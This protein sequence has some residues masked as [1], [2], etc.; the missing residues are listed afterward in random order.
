[1]AGAREGCKKDRVNREHD[2]GYRR[3]LSVKRVFLDFLRDFVTRDLMAHIDQ[4]TLQ[5]VQQSFVLPDFSGKEADLVYSTLIGEPKMV[6]YVLTELQSTVDYLMPFRLH[7]YMTEI[8]REAYKNTDRKVSRRK[9]YPLPTVLPIVLYNGKRQWTAAREFRGKVPG[10]HYLTNKALNFDYV[11]VDVQRL[12]D[13]ALLKLNHVIAA[14]F[15]L[16]R[17]LDLKEF[18]ERFNRLAPKISRWSQQDRDLLLGWL[19]H[20]V[21]KRLPREDRPITEK[22]I[23]SLMEGSMMESA[24]AK[25][26]EKSIRDYIARGRK[27]GLKAGRTEGVQEGARK[28]GLEI[29]QRLL[30]QGMTTDQVADLTGLSLA[31]VDDLKKNQRL[32]TDS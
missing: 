16:D 30:Q 21:I 29:A 14:M 11:L 19:K 25:G 2:A 22:I 27:A 32:L 26:I 15:F 4:T 1:M 13:E 5:I 28:K 7:L 20:I 3:I 9:N 8:W 17:E 24:L 31:D 10:A 6:L 18:A 12:P 23:L